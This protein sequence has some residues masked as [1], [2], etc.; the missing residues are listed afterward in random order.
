MA[1]ILSVKNNLNGLNYYYSGINKRRAVSKRRFWRFKRPLIWLAYVVLA[2]VVLQFLYPWDKTLPFARMG[3]TEL[4]SVSYDQAADTL[5]SKYS[6]WTRTVRTTTNSYQVTAADIGLELNAKATAEKLG[7]VWWQRLLPGSFLWR[8]TNP[9]VQPEL[10]LNTVRLNDFTG[11]IEQGSHLAYKNATIAIKDGEPS[12]IPDE[13]GEDYPASGVALVLQREFFMA[14][15]DLRLKPKILKPVITSERAE[16]TLSD[17]QKILSAPP[18]YTIDGTQGEIAKSQLGEWLDFGQ[19]E[20]NKQLSIGINSGDI[21]AYL[22]SLYPYTYKTATGT[23]PGNTDYAVDA[24]SAI[25]GFNK[26]LEQKGEQLIIDIAKVALTDDIRVT[27]DYSPSQ[28]GLQTLLQDIVA[29]KGDYAIAM[30]QLGGFGWGASV[31]G[32]KKY[33]PASTYKLFVAYSV[34]KKIEA[35]EWTWG[36]R[37]AGYNLEYCFDIMIINSDNTCAEAFGNTLGWKNIEAQ[38]RD[39]GLKNTTLN[40]GAFISTANDELLFMTKL[41]RGEILSQASRDKLIDVMKRQ[42]YR[43]GIPAGTGVPVADKVGFLFGL[44]HDAALVYSPNGTYAL[45]ILTNGSSWQQIA[46]AAARIES[47]LSKR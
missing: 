17:T 45:V 21:E 6:S 18:K 24:V 36:G 47:Q 22:N 34:L 28:L 15:D 5:G 37:M 44:L 29:E 8:L 43:D 31:N 14:A 16:P 40:S 1:S 19:D 35:G 7:Y 41:G 13:P 46:D 20:A 11:R 30:Q 25:S 33:T 42:V 27:R 10:T 9:N 4:S 26:V 32:D 2:V 23:V 38:M 12:I 3:E 39:L